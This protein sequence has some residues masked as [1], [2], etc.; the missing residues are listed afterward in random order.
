MKTRTALAAALV[1]IA[2]GG[3]TGCCRSTCVRACDGPRC[4][5]V[6]TSSPAPPQGA[7]T[8]SVKQ[9]AAEGCIRY[10]TNRQRGVVVMSCLWEDQAESTRAL[11]LLEARGVFAFG[12]TGIG[13]AVVV[14]ESDAATARSILEADEICRK[15]VMSETK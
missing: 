5:A 9:P 12:D 2:V 1:A 10:R 15:F 13:I 3:V 11:S 7:P 14:G 4:V 6:R 8:A